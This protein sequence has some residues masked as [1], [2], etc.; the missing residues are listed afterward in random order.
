MARRRRAGRQTG[1]TAHSTASCV[2]MAIT[3]SAPT[4]IPTAVPA[5]ALRIDQPVA[6]AF[7]RST[8]SVPSTT[9]NPCWRPVRWAMKTATAS[10]AAPR[11]L[12]WNQTDPTPACSTASPL[13]RR[14]ARARGRRLGDVTVLR[15]RARRLRSPAVHSRRSGGPNTTPPGSETAAQAPPSALSSRLAGR[16]SGSRRTSARATASRAASSRAKSG[17]SSRPS[18][19]SALAR[20]TR[21]RRRHRLHVLFTDNLESAGVDRRR[22]GRTAASRARLEAT[23]A[24]P[25]VRSTRSDGAGM[26]RKRLPQTVDRVMCKAHMFGEVIAACFCDVRNGAQ[27]AWQ[28]RAEDRRAGEAA[29]AA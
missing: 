8:E 3:S 25:S 27:R 20:S 9:Q 18:R 26:P 4:T 28:R 19:R 11:T 1:S 13:G 2:P 22:R 5:R 17:R 15:A 29:T 6:S 12:F 21:R 24:P 7:D 23:P 10:P 16:S 14:Q